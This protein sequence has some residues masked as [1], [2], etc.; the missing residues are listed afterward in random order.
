[1]I[2]VGRQGL[3]GLLVAGL[4][5]CV[6][7]GWLLGADGDSL[8]WG[9]TAC[10]WPS[11]LRG[12]FLWRKCSRIDAGCAGMTVPSWAVLLGRLHLVSPLVCG[13]SVASTVA[14]IV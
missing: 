11:W 10:G 9:D 6:V 12:W 14:C 1:M 13:A 8:V 2:G 3:D 7:L 5:A 4:G